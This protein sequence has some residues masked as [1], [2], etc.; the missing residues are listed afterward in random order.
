MTTETSWV[1]RAKIVATLGPATDRAEIMEALIRAG[2]NVVRLNFSYGSHPEHAQRIALV[3]AAAERSGQPVAILQDLQGPKIRTGPLAGGGPIF[4]NEGHEIVITTKP[5]VGTVERIDTSYAALPVDVRPGDRLM[6]SDGRIV[7]RVLAT[8]PGEVRCLVEGGGRLAERQ[9]ISMPEVSISAPSLTPKNEEDLAFGLEQ[10]VDC[11]ALSF[12]RR[13]ADLQRVRDFM[14]SRGQVVPLIAKIETR[15]AVDNLHAVLAASDGVMVARG[16][17]GVEVGPERVPVIQKLIV[18]EARALGI[19]CIVATQMLEAM[20]D[21]PLPT[22]AEASDVANAAWEAADVPMLSGETAVGQDPVAVVMTMA[23]IITEAE[24]AAHRLGLPPPVDFHQFRVGDEA[25]AISHAAQTLAAVLGVRAIV[26][27]TR[28]GRTAR[29]LSAHRPGV[30]VYAFT[31]D[32]RIYRWMTL[33]WGV[34]PLHCEIPEHADTMIELMER[35]LL[36]LGLAAPDDVVL[37]VV[38]MP[39]R[40]GVHTN[41]MKIHRLS[42]ER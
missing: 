22:R 15:E 26:G 28:T 10:G 34:L 17:L 40:A 5:V 31:P 29:L 42:S 20:I 9:G 37:V 24:A 3:R 41:F 30:P 18:S 38:A 16:D 8:A 19:P 7:L 13:A 12:V 35:Q 25:V 36:G 4:L 39:L 32:D 27:L 21:Q 14:M 6:L 1:R 23:R 11:V 2:V 33:W